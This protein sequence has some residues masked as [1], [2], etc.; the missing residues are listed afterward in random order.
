MKR[1][2][3]SRRKRTTTKSVLRLPD[4]EHAKAAVLNSLTSLV[5]PNGVIVTPSMNSLTGIVRNLAWL[6]TEL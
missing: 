3:Y 1:T 5:T 2:P 4:L 6:S